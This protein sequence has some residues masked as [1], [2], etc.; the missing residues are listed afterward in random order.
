MAKRMQ[1]MFRIQHSSIIPVHRN[2]HYL[3]AASHLHEMSYV[4]TSSCYHSSSFDAGHISPR[5]PYHGLFNAISRSK[6]FFYICHVYH[7]LIPNHHHLSIA[8]KSYCC[9]K[10]VNHY[11]HPTSIIM[12]GKHFVILLSHVQS[13][14]DVVVKT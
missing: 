3:F 10:E 7:M 2:G 11:Q 4:K 12:Q 14:F 9:S 1:R 5:K 13:R 6:V 8:L